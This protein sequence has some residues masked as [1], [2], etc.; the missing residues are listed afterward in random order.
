M[1]EVVGGLALLARTKFFFKF[2]NV[3]KHVLNFSVEDLCKRLFDVR[4]QPIW[5]HALS[6]PRFL[7][8][9]TSG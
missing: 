6:A 8:S 2:L 4:I 3:L 7:S 9:G 5:I 1:I